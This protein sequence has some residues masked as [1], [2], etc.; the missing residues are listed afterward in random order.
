[1]TPF[2]FIKQFSKPYTKWY[3]LTCIAPIYAGVHSALNSWV[4]KIIIDTITGNSID[5]SDFINPFVMFIAIDLI[6]RFFWSLH[7]YSEYKVHGRV[8]KDLIVEPYKYLQKHSYEYFQNTFAGSITSKIKGIS[9]GFYKFWDDISHSLLVGLSVILANLLLIGF[10]APR[11]ILP[12][13]SYVIVM[14][15]ICYFQ[16]KFYKI[17][18][19]E[20]KKNYHIVIGNLA[21][22]IANI[23]TI[24]SFAKQD[25]EAK[26]FGDFYDKVQTPALNRMLLYNFKAWILVG[27][28]NTMMMIGIFIYAIYLRKNGYITTGVLAATVLIVLKC[29]DNIFHFVQ[30][31][32]SF[33]QHFADFKASIEGIYAV[34]TPI[35][36]ANAADIK[37]SRGSIEFKNISF[38]YGNNSNVFKNLN[39]EIKAGQKIGLVGSSGAGKST[40]IGLLL[41]NFQA[42]SGDIVI[43]NQSIYN[44]SSDSLRSQISVIPQD[45]LLFHRSIGENIGYANDLASQQEIEAAA[46]TANIHEFISTLPDGY[47]TLVGERGLKLS[48]GQ[49][50]RIAIARS[51][52]K[53]APILI[54][55]EATSALD[56]QTEQEIQQSINRILETDNTSTVIAIAHRLSTIK[57]MDKIIVIENGEIVEDGSF[58]ELIS[59]ANGKFKKMWDSQVDGMVV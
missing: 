37:I 22:N 59:K 36:K 55:D 24:L 18:N 25:R 33:V 26:K 23:F 45:I 41:K 48:G 20:Q 15:I 53:N 8:F 56:S 10:L 31:L 43:D 52:L 7:D 49:R 40:L 32:L 1:M 21:D 12:V 29:C 17:Q 6:G 58:N 28:L 16:T 44:H 42:N 54:L 46:K 13:A 47:N 35:D 39:L 2:L 9:D 4:I 50:Q 11:L 27:L 3:I 30:K 57:H 51:I 38:G 34:Q 5:Y 19:Y 14:G